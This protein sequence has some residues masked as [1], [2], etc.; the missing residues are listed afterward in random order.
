MKA[1]LTRIRRICLSLPEA[2]EVETWASA[3]FRVGKKIFAMAADHP[4]SWSVSMKTAAG[5]QQALL[6][7][8]DPYFCPP[9]VGPKGWI[10]I[11]L[12]SAHL[13]WTEV[14]E[15]IRDSYRLVAPK[16]LSAGLS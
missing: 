16:K 10:G 1:P 13:D 4:T 6:A 7:H 3:T 15:L 8:G 2:Y 12:T 14:A 9:Y 5:E 11:D